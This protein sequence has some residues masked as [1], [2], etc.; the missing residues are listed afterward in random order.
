MPGQKILLTLYKTIE[1]QGN[2]IPADT[3]LEIFSHGKQTKIHYKKQ[4]RVK[5]ILISLAYDQ[6]CKILTEYKIEANAY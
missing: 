1:I 5:R 4:G 6:V 2:M 3:Q